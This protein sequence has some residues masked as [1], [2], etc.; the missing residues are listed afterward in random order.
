MLDK[1]QPVVMMS[2]YD[3]L[4]HP[5][6]KQLG[7]QVAAYAK[8]RKAKYGTKSVSNPAYQGEVMIYT[9]EFLDECFNAKK[10]FESKYEDLT[11]IN[12]QLMQDSNPN[13]VF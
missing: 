10:V 7:E 1:Q 2:L 4:K 5:A 13:L 6:G 11:E 3:Y 9:K 12:T 8:L